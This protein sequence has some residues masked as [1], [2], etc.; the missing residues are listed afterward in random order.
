MSAALPSPGHPAWFV[1]GTDTEVGKTHCSATLLAALVRR[2]LRAVGMKP[3]AA[4]LDR[5]GALPDDAMR[6]IAS[7]NV[8]APPRWICP[9]ALREPVAPHLAAQIDGVR[10]RPEPILNAFAALRGLADAVVVE[11]VGGFRVPLDLDPA[12]RWDTADLA[13]RLQLPVVLVVGLRLGCLNHA[14]LTAEAIA[15]RGLRLAGWIANRIDPQ[16]AHPQ[17]SIDTLH[18]LLP[19]PFLGDV[20]HGVPP[21]AAAELL[22]LGPLFATDSGGP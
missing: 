10:L 20:P 14:L 8:D 12:T 3:V 2:G 5:P 1:T 11:G 17:T 9:Y 6:L 18:A 19:A 15:A 21:A 13:V 22:D 7:G 4:G 16:M